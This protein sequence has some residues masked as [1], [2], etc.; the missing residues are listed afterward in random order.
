MGADILRAHARL[1]E[2]DSTSSNGRLLAEFLEAL[3]AGAGL[4]RG[5]AVDAMYPSRTASVGI[6]PDAVALLDLS[7]ALSG[8]RR[9]GAP[10]SPETVSALFVGADPDVTD[11]RA[12]PLTAGDEL[13]AFAILE[14]P[15]SD[16]IGFA[17]VIA[18]AASLLSRNRMTERMRGTDFELKIRVWELESLYDVGLSIAGTLDMESLADDILM[19][20]VSLLNAR[21]GTLLVRD[22]SGDGRLLVKDFGGALLPDCDDLELPEDVFIA[23]RVSDRIGALLLSP[24]ETLLAV[25]IKS[26]GRR[27]GVLVVA[28]KE[29]RA[30][31]IDDF[32]ESDGRIL[33]LFANQAAIALENARLHRDA[34]EKERIEREI[35]LAASI[36]KA[37]L[38]AE[39]PSAPGLLMAGGN[40]PTRAVGGDYF[41]VFPL[42]DGRTAFV[43][44]DVSG[45]GVPAALLVSTV[46]A[47]L[48]L[49]VDD[50]KT[51]LPSL[52]SRINRHLV[53]F[54]A[55]RKFVTL[56]FALYEPKSRELRYV[57]AG[58]NPG[59]WLSEGKVELLHSTGLPIG[60]LP[61]VVH[62]QE[63][64]RLGPSDVLVLYSD[65]ITEAADAL[66]EEFGM[67]RLT[68]LAVAGKLHP[69]SQLSDTIFGAVADFTRGVPQYDD[70]TVL[71]A[72][73]L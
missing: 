70:Q 29:N 39:L 61:N 37:I 36:Q 46:H 64:I 73:A 71:V 20:S 2:I 54:S 11:P 48:H 28:D 3:L 18:H 72:R 65:G 8:T 24:A 14:G 13:L 26:E 51:D 50:L 35:E 53:F 47:C 6:T 21:K 58:H 49:L 52:V 19:K 43:V 23:N 59:I 38:P 55:T 12:I 56:F 66:D 25:A 57:N 41:D 15:P 40:R 32:N 10:L 68:G 67:E 42:P 27:L 22:I 16:P 5:L 30:G 9:P 34:L 62:Q 1:A 63:M 60:M 4:S 33:S 7:A 45:K 17:S 69:P 44:A 31:G